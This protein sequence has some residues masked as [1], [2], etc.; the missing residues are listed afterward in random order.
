ML[1]SQSLITVAKLLESGV[2]E[3]AAFQQGDKVLYV[4]KTSIMK[5][6]NLRP[7]MSNN[8]HEIITFTGLT[9][10]IYVLYSKDYC[11]S[12][13]D[14]DCYAS[15]IVGFLC[16]HC[17]NVFSDRAKIHKQHIHLHSGPVKCPSCKK[18]I[19]DKHALSIHKKDCQFVC[20]DCGKKFAK[21]S[22]LTIH[23]RVHVM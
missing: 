16:P 22:R 15:N 13:V 2:S 3:M 11:V 7:S 18:L 6:I 12:L 10:N 17:G 5:R 4:D 8:R 23:E 1:G 19:A 20:K 9:D 14:L 21:K